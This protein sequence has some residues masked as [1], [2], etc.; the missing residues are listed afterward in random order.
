MAAVF[1]F[2]IGFQ[3]YKK[4]LA[5]VGP[6]ATAATSV[7]GTSFV[8]NWNTYDGATTYYLDVSISSSFSTFVLQNQAV[9]APTTSYTV[10]GL[11]A[12][13]TYYYRV[14]AEGF[15]PTISVAPTLSPSGSQITGTV[16]TC[17]TGT[18]SS[19]GS[20]FNYKWKR[21][22]VDI[23]GATSN[24]YT[25]QAIDDGTTITCDVQNQNAFGKSA[26]V[27]TS[28]SVSATVPILDTYTNA[29]V[30]Y[31]V[32]KLR[33]AYTGNAIRVRRSTDN[34]EQNIGFANGGNLDTTAL[35]AF[36]GAGNGFVTTWYDQSG[37]GNNLRQ[38]TAANQ[39]QIVSSGSVLTINTKPYLYFTSQGEMQF[40]SILNFQ[41]VDSSLFL[42]NKRLNSVSAN[43]AVLE[44]N[45]GYIYLNYSTIIAYG[46]NF[47]GANSALNYNLFTATNDVG[48][49][50]FIY[51]NNVNIGTKNPSTGTGVTA[52]YLMRRAFGQNDYLF[53]E[54]IM[55]AIDQNSVRNDI[56]TNINNYYAI[57]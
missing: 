26:Y 17:G 40:T 56:N 24:T 22:G 3:F 14:R 10:T 7:T 23:T 1:G 33:A 37:N 57:Y 15:A 29:A 13:T 32:R 28:N 19:Q 35:T 45:G 25:I 47:F 51:R 43:D 39:P 9:S 53:T 38:T 12:C 48:A 8:A 27:G 34:A 42:V 46:S 30:A 16:I 11:T 44:G 49:N 41:S 54:L 18:W 6:V 4:G 5:L 55:Y 36:C 2:G 31:S 21:N 50:L 20:I 52:E